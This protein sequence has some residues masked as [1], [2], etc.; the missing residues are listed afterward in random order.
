MGVWQVKAEALWASHLTAKSHRLNVQ[1][2]QKE[3]EQAAA[4]AQAQAA[5]TAAKGKRRADDEDDQSVE[6]TPGGTAKRVRFS[7]AEEDGADVDGE[8]AEA[9]TSGL[10][11]GFFD[12][13]S[14]APPPTVDDADEDDAAPAPAEDEDPEWAA[15][16]ATLNASD[17]K[18]SAGEAFARAT[19][20]AEPVIYKQPDE[21]GEEAEGQEEEV[22]EGEEEGPQETEEERRIR[23]EKEEIM[24]RIETY[25]TSVLPRQVTNAR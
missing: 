23:E 25:V 9:P 8:A 3:Q 1:R 12:D 21:E 15:F 17:A 10:P 4:A 19:V 24:E 14:Q 22:E 5:A 13:P 6:R 20:M 16:E 18:A 2:L 7:E 11:A